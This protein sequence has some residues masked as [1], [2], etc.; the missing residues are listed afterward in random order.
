[1][2]KKPRMR[3]RRKKKDMDDDLDFLDS[4][5]AKNSKECEE[6][7][8]SNEE[9]AGRVVELYRKRRAKISHF[10]KY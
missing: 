9:L 6:Q 1:M 4:V 7:E 8:K 2:K 10:A 5:V 3:N